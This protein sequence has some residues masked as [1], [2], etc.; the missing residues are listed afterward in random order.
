MHFCGNCGTRLG[1][2][3]EVPLP[4]QLGVLMGADL[5]ERLHQAGIEAAGQRRSVTILFTDLTGFTEL[6][7]RT[8]PEDLY[9]LMQQYLRV[10]INAVY[11]YEGMVDKLTGDGLMA[12]F[13]APIA[14]ENNA[15]RAVLAA[16]DMQR[17]LQQLNQELGTQLGIA[18]QMRIGLHA[19]AVI[20]GGIGSNMLM[21]YTAIGDTVNLARRIE[22][23][24][25]SGAILVSDAV[26][27]QTRVLFDYTQVTVLNPKGVHH[28][29]LAYRALG[30]KAQP[31]R[32]RGI[33]GLH[34]PMIGRERELTRLQ[35]AVERLLE[36]QVGELLM[37]TG[38]AGLGKSR[39]IA[40]FKARLDLTRLHV[41]EGQSLAYRRSIPYWVFQDLF[42]HLLDVATDAPEARLRAR[43]R[44]VT[45]ARLGERA[46]AVLPFLEMLF[47]LA[48]SD[49]AAAERLA[50]LDAGQL[51]RQIFLASRAWILAEAQHKPLVILLEDLHWADESSL[52]LL[53]FWLDGLSEAPVVMVAVSRQVQDS[54]LAEMVTWAEQHLGTRFERVA[55]Q[56]LSQRQ[57]AALLDQLLAL[58]DLP[59]YLQEMIVQRAAG[60]PFYLEEILR[61]LIDSQVFQRQGE[62]WAWNR[63]VDLT[64]LGVPETLQGLILTRFDHLPRWERYVLQTAAVIGKN[65]RLPVL[66]AVLEAASHLSEAGEVQRALRELEAREFVQAQVDGDETTFTFRHI[67]M[68]DAIYGTLLKRDRREIHGRVGQVLETL[69]ADR[70]DSQVELLANHY[71][72]SALPE[73]AVHYLLL[74]GA[75]AARGYANQQARQNFAWAIELLPEI[76]ATTEQV[77]QAYM[78]LGDVLIL[79]GDYP[80]ARQMYLTALES[81]PE[82]GWVSR[83]SELRRKLGATDERQG[84]YEAALSNYRAAQKLLVA[85]P[86]PYPVEQALVL[87]EIGWTYFRRGEQDEALAALYEAL[88]HLEGVAA[89]EV[90]ASIYNRLGGVYYQKDQLDQASNYVRKSLVLRQ[91][92][93]DFVAVARS[94]NNLG[95]L[96]WKKGDWDNALDNFQHSLELHANLGDV[97]GSVEVNSNLALLQ[98]D[99]GEIDVAR[100]HLDKA[101]T[102]A[103]A[104]GHTYHI[105]ILDLYLA[106]LNVQAGDPAAALGCC[107][108]S[109]AALTSIGAQDDIINV[110]TFMGFAHL[111]LNDLSKAVQCAS[112]A[113]A[114]ADRLS[115]DK[116]PAPDENRGWTYRLFGEIA[117]L[118]G[119]LTQ[120]EVHFK[121][122]AAMFESIGSQIEQGRSMLGLARLTYACGEATM[123]RMYLSEAR[124]IFQQLGAR[125]DLAQ[126]GVLLDEIRSAGV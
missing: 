124:L 112:Q 120:A 45:V 38:E 61:M 92:L 88:T 85:Q 50:Y 43:L 84:E 111:R 67:L 79:T 68:S 121:A 102:I 99:R 98:L 100:D 10:L 36:E 91:E 57:S 26:Y 80:T 108:R 123:A 24:A 69:Y 104:I 47:A 60:I 16:I 23:A 51:R 53:R 78:G 4:E 41:L 113:Q 22:E 110:Y 42:R 83:R 11:R 71:R 73:R 15:E 18:L 44:E 63:E 116:P 48:P 62:G 56:S 107:E 76:S 58:P 86:Q 30:V 39:L 14:H 9:D 52:D 87:S 35:T 75:R 74:A 94:Y 13:G 2:A 115:G 20:V 8:D 55:L 59:Q 1:R 31:G 64:S 105:G 81:L 12:L 37:V 3:P 82:T 29:V 96:G 19:G 90:L 27:R 117:L 6:S 40:E 119:N 97:E 93:G 118:Q 7:A 89:Y 95:L 65:F 103:E 33:E 101:R 28:P 72:W 21:N 70:L 77:L 126:A 17:D 25:P 32:V 49:P 125:Q 114:L 66:Q 5:L 54:A 34:A 106:R 109:L 122:S 46:E